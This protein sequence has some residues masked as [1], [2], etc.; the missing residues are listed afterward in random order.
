MNHKTPLLIAFLTISVIACSQSKE[1]NST[2]LKGLKQG[3]WIKKYPN[4]SIMYEG[5][6]KDDHPVGEF[7]RYYENKVLKSLLIYS[8]DGSEIMATIYHPNGY[9]AS[10]GKY[11]NQLKEGVWQ[12]FSSFIDG[13][14]ISEEHYSGNIRNGVSLKFYPDST[15]AE[16]VIY[17]DGMKEGEW[18]QNYT[19]GNICLKSY[20]L[21][22]K[23]QGKFQVW[24]ENGNIQFSGQY[25]NDVRD[26]IWFIYNEDGSLRYKIEYVDGI[27][28]DTQMDIDE[29]DYFDQLD[30]NKGKIADPEKTGII[31]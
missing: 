18:T 10:K 2:D 1:I 30:K 19:N 26:G 16:K 9:I 25:K 22:D 28:K 5:F 13:Y 6:F 27:T 31:R 24:H 15:I 8:D 23:R 29:S 12:F 20:Y 7:K 14:L 21:N 3:A 11:I 17:V 4:K